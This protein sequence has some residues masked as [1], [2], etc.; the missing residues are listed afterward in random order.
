MHA[1]IKTILKN[2]FQNLS[3]DSL[4]FLLFLTLFLTILLAGCKSPTRRLDHNLKMPL[5]SSQTLSLSIDSEHMHQ[6]M[7]FRIYLPKGFDSN[8]NYPILYCFHGHGCDESFWSDLGLLEQAD[9]L[10]EQ[11]ILSPCILVLPYIRDSR[12]EELEHE[13]KMNGHLGE[14][15]I[16]LYVTQEL[17]PYVDANYTYETQNKN[18][19]K[20]YIGGFSEGGMIALRIA[21]HHPDLFKKVG[22][23]SPALLSDRF[24]H[25][26]LEKWL[27]KDQTELVDDENTQKQFYQQN[28]YQEL[29]L[30]IDAGTNNDPFLT[31]IQSF[32]EALEKR[33]LSSQF[34]SYDGGHSMDPQRFRDYL[35]F[36]FSSSES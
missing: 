26:E 32:H 24:S 4:P 18:S 33:S 21:L 27:F 23:Y 25:N 30:Y 1:M 8:N 12:I 19:S 36:Y 35:L 29:R 34:N 11:G 15:I 9:E 10:I 14:R 31:R 5:A 17:I 7:P 16:D 20:R 22:A 6:T 3:N 2:T 28:T 13:L